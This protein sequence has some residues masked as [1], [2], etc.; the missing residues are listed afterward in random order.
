MSQ[1]LSANKARLEELEAAVEKERAAAEAAGADAP[2]APEA[3]E[4][5]AGDAAAEQPAAAAA[6]PAVDEI[7]AAMDAALASSGEDGDDA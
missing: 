1:F 6:P 5:P 4:P 7:D 2:A 3:N